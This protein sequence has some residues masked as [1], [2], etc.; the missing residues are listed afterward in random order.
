MTDEQE[1][2]IDECLAIL[3][4]LWNRSTSMAAT[5]QQTQA[6]IAAL[7]T[8]V[9]STVGVEQ[10]ALVLIQGLPA[11]IQA[12][13]AGLDAGTAAAVTAAFQPLLTSATA[14]AAAVAANQPPAPVPAP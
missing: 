2:K 14:L 9:A 4:L 3:K 1:G 11:I 12:A 6:A 13:V 5:L 7:T 10:S 8:Q